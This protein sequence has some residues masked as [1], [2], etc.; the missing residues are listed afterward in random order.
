MKKATI[1]YTGIL[2][3][4][5]LSCKTKVYQDKEMEIA[6]PF[7]NIFNAIAKQDQI[8]FVNDKGRKKSF[9]ISEIDSVIKNE[10]GCFVNIIPYKNLS[11]NFYQKGYDTLDLERKNEPWSVK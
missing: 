2:I 6:S 8:M 9:S 11:I 5:F 4:L 3:V 1:L 10:K 7:L